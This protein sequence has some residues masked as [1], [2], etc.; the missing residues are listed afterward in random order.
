MSDAALRPASVKTF[1]ASVPG[2]C[3]EWVQGWL[4]GEPVLVSCPIR[5][6]AV[7]RVTLGPDD[8]TRIDPPD[9]VKALQAARAVAA[10]AGHRGGLTVVLNSALPLGR[11]YAS[12][13]ADLVAA[14]RAT[15][16]AISYNLPDSVIGRLAC[17]IEPSDSL[18]FPGWTLFA[19]RCG[20]W[21]TP[22]GPGLSLPLVVLDTGQ[23]IDT[24]AFNQ[25]LD[26]TRVAALEPTTREAVALLK[27][28]LVQADSA[29][30]GAAAMLSARAYQAI[31][32]SALVDQ[33]LRWAS[34]FRAAGVVRAHSGSLVGLV[35]ASA[36]AAADVAQWLRPSFAGETKVTRTL[37]TPEVYL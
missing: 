17:A 37:A 12:S 21:H 10:L 33:V 6:Y 1:S 20:A 3:G 32:Y 29:V 9:R 8:V 7:V 4:S 18:M 34:E 16:E 15:A 11:G 19:Y 26:L 28:G 23:A 2:T 31:A 36:E 25:G 5:R 14:S 35:F 13:T 24:V 27:E 30:I 22:L